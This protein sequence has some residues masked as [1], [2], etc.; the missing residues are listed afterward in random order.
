MIRPRVRLQPR[1]LTA[2]GLAGREDL[3][4]FEQVLLRN[5]DWS[6]AKCLGRWG[7]ILLYRVTLSSQNI[8]ID[9]AF[10]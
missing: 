5:F 1:V 8:C 7:L 6:S 2:K 9:T 3:N 4:L 10:W